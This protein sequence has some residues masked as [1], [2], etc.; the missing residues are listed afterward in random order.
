MSNK[1][2]LLFLLSVLSIVLLGILIIRFF[3]I[4]QF[5]T[6]KPDTKFI[7]KPIDRSEASEMFGLSTLPETSSNIY[8]AKS[9]IGMGGR[10][11]AFRFDA[12]VQDCLFYAQTIM[13]DKLVTNAISK[14]EQW[15]NYDIA[16]EHFG[17]ADVTAWFDVETVTNGFILTG[18]GNVPWILID[19]HGRLY[20]Y[21]SD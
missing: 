1:S 12:P 20:Y 10:V 4:Y 21:R 15:P 2:K 11:R 9:T 18:N 3:L 17:L 7:N 13:P 19:N 5:Q 6:Q 8:Y 16:F 14:D